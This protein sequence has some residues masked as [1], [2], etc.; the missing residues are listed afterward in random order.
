MMRP[1]HINP[2]Q[3][4]V[5]LR[6]GE[7]IHEDRKIDA[8]NLIVE[9]TEDIT[10]K[11]Q[12]HAKSIAFAD[13][14]LLATLKHCLDTDNYE[15]AAS[16]LWS[17]QLFS[18]K[19]WATRMVWDTI[20][21]YH[22]VLLMGASSMSKTFGC[23]VF[24]YLDWLRD[25]EHTTI[26]VVGPGESHLESNLFSHLVT[27]HRSCALPVPGQVG[28]LF[29]GLDPRDQKS[30]IKGLTIPLGRA[31]GAGRLQGVKRYPRGHA[32][33]VFGPQF[34]LRVL[35]DEIEKVPDGIWKDFR[36]LSSN[37]G[38]YEDGLKIACAF[39]PEM[40]G[41]QTYQHA[42]PPQGWAA[43]DPD[44]DH[45]WESKKGWYVVRLDAHRCE[46]VIEGKEIYPG[47][48]TKRGLD[49][50]AKSSG[51]VDSAGYFTFGRALY[52]IQGSTLS[53]IPV[54]MFGSC[55]GEF[56]WYDDPQVL[57][58]VDSSLEGTDPPVLA[59]GRFGMASGIVL[60]PS[61][62]HPQGRKVIF[63]Q[64][65]GRP[66]LRPA[67]HVSKL[68]TLENSNTVK[69]SEQ[70][71]VMAQAL[72]IPPDRMIIDR[73]GNGAGVHDLLKETWA[74]EVFGLNYSESATKT[75]VMQEDEDTCYD[76]YYRVYSELWYVFRRWLEF[77][78]VIFAPDLEDF[79]GVQT[80]FTSRMAKPT[81][82]GL[83]KV[84]SKQDYKHRNG[85]QS[86]N[87]ADAITLLLHLVRVRWAVIPSMDTE[88]TTASVSD[89]DMIHQRA[90][91]VLV[92]YTDL[93]DDLDI[94]QGS[95]PYPE[96]LDWMS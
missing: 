18:A 65:S 81:G 38:S 60:P 54:G 62:E 14:V 21:R 43:L 25:P 17:E 63:K 7:L 56:I 40:V 41:S 12:R 55:R 4:D 35:V 29:I 59:L 42:E 10:K 32:H 51:G 5:I 52:P 71:K 30:A 68:F 57:G 37:I 15:L 3:K 77:Q 24:Y 84:E 34:R 49:I 85:G 89:V 33:P 73:T 16:L 36:N 86:P 78:F 28:A 64:G 72:G 45:E 88:R 76:M 22:Q 92:S 13:E 53:I 67:L 58:A 20:R 11:K 93:L 46:N 61:M 6:A 9:F 90:M 23:G 2:D 94:K 70:I 95:G 69:M 50:L 79:A 83:K 91:P 82:K 48:Q 26:R 1:Q 47:L 75:K 31:A 27:L 44:K 87:R 39:N 80:E 96:E 8:A 19:P 74:P 66:A